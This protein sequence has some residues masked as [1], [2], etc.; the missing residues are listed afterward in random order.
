MFSFPQFSL[1]ITIAWSFI[2]ASVI[3]L[4][5]SGLRY[6]LLNSSFCQL[7][8]V[9]FSFF[10]VICHSFIHFCLILSCPVLS[11]PTSSWLVLSCPVLFCLFL[12]CLVPFCPVLS[13]FVQYC[14][15]FSHQVLPC[16]VMS[17]HISSC[18]VISRHISSF[19]VM[20]DAVSSCLVL[21]CH[22]YSCIVLSRPVPLVLSCLVP[23]VLFHS[24]Y[25]QQ[26]TWRS[27]FGLL[28][29]SIIDM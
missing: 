24:N 19:L 26:Y 13:P 2:V 15:L 16:L 22:V 10:L 17:R 29:C 12:S 7:C 8:P 1:I 20:S 23:S 18:L 11:H 21:S 27:D 14:P 5:T 25:L 4:P 9:S 6:Y 3:F 28:L